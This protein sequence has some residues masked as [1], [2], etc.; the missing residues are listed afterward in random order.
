MIKQTAIKTASSGSDVTRLA[1]RGTIYITASKAWFMI[2][3]LG[4]HLTLP[5]LM[6]AEMFGLYQVTVSVV[7]VINAVVVTGTYQTVSKYVSQEEEK[8]GAVKSKALKLQ[9]AVGGGISAGFFLLAPVIAR[10]MNDDRLI[11]YLRLAS[12]ITLSYSFYSVFTGYFNGL[13]RFLA[14]AVLDMTYSTL[15]LV[16]I[17]SLVWLGYGVAGGIGGFALAAASVLAVSAYLARGAQ[18]RGEVRAADLFQF[19]SYLLLS[20]LVFNLLQKV[21]IILVKSLSS[22]D[23]TLASVNAGYYGGAINMANLTYQIIVSVTFVIFPLVSQATFSNDLERTRGYISTTL[24]YTL[25]MMAL[26]ATLFSANA[27]EALRVIYPENYQAAT[28]A[29]SVVAYGMLFFGLLFI[30]TTIISASGRPAVSLI[31]CIVSLVASATFNAVLVPRF[32]IDGAAIGTTASMIVGVVAGGG[33]ILSRYGALVPVKSLARIALASGALYASSLAFSPAS[34]LL[35]LVQLAL[36]PVVYAVVLV[37]T[38]ELG[39]SD[40]ARIKRVIKR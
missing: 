23:P 24:R 26:V 37:A 38:G 30:L 6:T 31:V 28:V 20:T 19:Q 15:K 14:Q 8:A 16:M 21:D 25:M 9:L 32:G 11:D 10:F 2:S 40:L 3:G 1:G 12:L 7:S 39:A 33:Y 18:K 27:A 34:K 13:K 4:I 17:V 5:S 36:L 29:L 35:I 22:S